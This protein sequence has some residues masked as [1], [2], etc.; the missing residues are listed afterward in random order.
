M[1]SFGPDFSWWCGESDAF[2]GEERFWIS[3]AEWFKHLQLFDGLR[4]ELCEFC[5][6]VDLELVNDVIMV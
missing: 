6:G 3:L 1:F 2:C 5:G 4:T